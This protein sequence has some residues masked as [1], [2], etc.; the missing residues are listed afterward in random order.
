MA[1]QTH[2]A[3]IALNRICGLFKGNPRLI[4]CYPWQRVESVNV[5]ADT[6]L[7]GC[8]RTRK[9]TS[10]GSAM[11]GVH[12]LK[13]W[14]STQASTALISGEAEFYGVVCGLGHGLRYQALMRELGIKLPLRVWTDSSAAIGIYRRH[15]LRKLRRLDAQTLWVQQT[16]RTKR[17][18]L[19]K[20]LGEENLADLFAKH[21]FSRTS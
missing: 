10:G 17:L 6:D 5:C 2:Q 21:Y 9:S 19:R 12:V 18:E 16:V 11:L 15:G 8:P 3:V 20:V 13:H 1:R 7:A 14:S 4:D